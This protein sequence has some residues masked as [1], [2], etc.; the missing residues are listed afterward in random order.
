MAVLLPTIQA[1]RFAV[2]ARKQAVGLRVVQETLAGGVPAHLAAQPHG[3]VAQVR[4]RDR[5]VGDLDGRDGL[6][7][8][9]DALEEVRVHVGAGVEM[10]L[11][12]LDGRASERRRIRA[13]L[14]VHPA[15]RALEADASAAARDDHPQ[16]VGVERLE[17]ER[18][19]GVPE[20][21]VARVF[22]LALH[23]DGA[24]SLGAHAPVGHVHEVR[25]PVGHLPARVVVDPAEGPVA[26]LVG[27]GRP[28][29]GAEPAVVVEALGH[30]HRLLAHAVAG[31]PVAAGQADADGREPADAAV[32]DQL[33]R[34]AARAARAPL[35]AALEDAAVAVH[36][37]DHRLAV[38]DRERERLLAVDVLARFRGGDDDA[39]VPVVRRRHGNRVNVLAGEQ[40]AEVLGG[41]DAFVGAI[42]LL[43]RVVAFDG[44]P[45]G[46]EAAVP[47]LLVAA[48][49]GV[50]VAQRGDL[51]LGMAEERPQV[52]VPLAAEADAA[53]HDA[54]ARRRP[55]LRAQCARGHD[56]G[57]RGQ[58]RHPAKEAAAIEG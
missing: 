11:R 20:D 13:A 9:A 51:H 27:V 41:E 33:A 40:L 8:R 3:D 44:L 24:G 38:G 10:N 5:A 46:G 50:H 37:A 58:G 49:A 31:V 28:G 21:A 19:G 45:G 42:A 17:A 25:A 16:A 29:R 7:P 1:P 43:G 56:T 34:V 6:L 12:R 48:A 39:R 30:G 57:R 47:A 18:G 35:A 26:A 53:H 2:D 54:A 36:G 55:P 15:L 4:D 23:L 52:A 32:A 14:E 22:R